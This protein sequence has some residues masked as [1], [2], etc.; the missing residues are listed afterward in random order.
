VLRTQQGQGE[1]W[2]RIGLVVGHV[3][4]HLF[5]DRAVWPSA[6]IAKPELIQTPSPAALNLQHMCRS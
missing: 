3:N 6:R 5:G 1:L 2:V 4:P